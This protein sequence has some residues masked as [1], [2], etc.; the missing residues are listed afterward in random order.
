MA[1]PRGS[2]QARHWHHA[3]HGGINMNYFVA[4][5]YG[6]HAQAQ[7]ITVPIPHLMFLTRL[8]WGRSPVHR[9]PVCSSTTGTGLEQYFWLS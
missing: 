2:E 7:G 6:P 5:Q 8:Q 9:K 1:M 3:N 4:I